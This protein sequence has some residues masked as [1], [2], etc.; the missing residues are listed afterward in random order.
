MAELVA[1]RGASAQATEN[2]IAAFEL[3]I[4]L[5]ADFIEF[6]V[7]RTKDGVL[8]I[9]HDD[10]LNGQLIS[11]W[12]YEDIAHSPH[13]AQIPT[14]I[15]TLERVSGRIKL[16]VEIKSLGCEKV[17]VDTLLR[18][19]DN[20]DFVIIS[21][22][23]EVI[24]A[25]K[26]YDPAVRVGLLL[27][28]RIDGKLAITRQ[29]VLHLRR[30]RACRADFIAPRCIP[31]MATSLLSAYLYGI[32]LYV[33]TINN[34]RH[35]RMISRLKRVETIGTDLPPLMAPWRLSESSAGIFRTFVGKFHWLY[36]L[37]RGTY[38]SGVLG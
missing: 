19:V 22:L 35:Y 36:H 11:D 38:I 15:Q 6:D 31:I 23:D 1:H 14:L 37:T 24:R 32:P 21:F 13:H 10:S 20:A 25:V 8:V 3:A 9:N 33:W 7:H 30:V 16:Y 5:H 27:V 28:Q 12:T 18:Y 17:V 29:D 2:T 4:E 26:A 34:P